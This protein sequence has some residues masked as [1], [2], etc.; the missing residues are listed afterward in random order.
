MDK[1]TLRK[2]QLTQL[3]IAKE[4]RRICDKYNIQYFLDS[5][6]LLGAVRHKGF[7]PWDDDLDI[8]MM[9]EEYE[10]FL[11]IASKELQEKYTLQV[12]SDENHYALSFAKIRNT[13]TVYIENKSQ[14]SQENQGIYV[15][16]FP[17]DRFGKDTFKQGF[18]LMLIRRM[19]LVKEKMEPWRDEGGI[20]AKRYI[21]YILIRILA[22]FFSKGNL[23]RYYEKKAQMYNNN[24]EKDYFP[25][26]TTPY[27]KWVIDK[28]ALE[29]VKL[30]SFEGEM[31]SV[32]IDSDLYLKNAYG[33]YMKLP[34]E[35][36]RENRHQILEVKFEE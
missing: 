10:R 2:V 30:M 15:D 23:I 22:L 20:S 12:W 29:E 7:I 36:Q 34:P 4:V 33:D 13:N 3:E 27:G 26:G 6:T 25:Q 28:S 1:E 9:R 16:I 32:P 24:Q 5:G 18:W 8:G 21:I 19:I 14:K 17:Y 31:F 11:Q 35:D